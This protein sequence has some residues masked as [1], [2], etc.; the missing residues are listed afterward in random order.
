MNKKIFALAVVAV[1]VMASS[2]HAYVLLSP[3]RTWASTPITVE[4]NNTGNS[5]VNDGSGGVSRVASAI[6]TWSTVNSQIVSA[7]ASRGDGTATIELHSNGRICTGS[8]LAATLTGYYT[9][10]GDGTYTIYDA[11]VYTNQNYSYVTTGE[12]DGC[13][14]EFY[15]EGIMVHEVGHVI[16]IGHSDVN[17]STM[18]PSVSYCDNGPASLHSDDQAAE[19]D[20]YSGGGGG[21]G[22]GGGCVDNDGDGYCADVD[23]NDNNSKVYPGANDTK[24][25]QGRDGID[26]DCD[27]VADR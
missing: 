17:G 13:S 15:L 18:Y 23:C 21:G 7:S 6:N 22:G 4:V 9:N 11:D 5:S 24:G 20:L 16:G 26:N 2:A 19:N 1:L 25:K 14:G 12:A 8:C 3:K 27:G 10:N